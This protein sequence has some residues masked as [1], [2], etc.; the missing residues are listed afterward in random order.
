MLSPSDSQ[1]R[2]SKSKKVLTELLDVQIDL[3]EKLK[4]EN[5]QYL[6][7][8][9]KFLALITKKEK[10]IDELKINLQKNAK[11]LFIFMNNLILEN[12]NFALSNLKSALK[13]FWKKK[14]LEK[15]LNKMS[16]RNL[17]KHFIGFKIN[18]IRKT[19]KISAAIV[20]ITFM[21]KIDI[22]KQIAFSKLFKTCFYSKQ[23]NLQNKITKIASFKIFYFAEK[24]ERIIYKK[25]CY[26]IFLLKWRNNVKLMISNDFKMKNMINIFQ[27]L[28]N[29]FFLNNKF[30]FLL[31]ISKEKESHSQ[32]YHNFISLIN[33]FI[34]KKVFWMNEFI[35]FEKIK[36]YARE[37]NIFEKKISK[38]ATI[39]F[40][41]QKRRLIFEL[42]LKTSQTSKAKLL[43]HAVKTLYAKQVIQC[44][45]F[46]RESPFQIPYFD[47]SCFQKKKKNVFRDKNKSI[48]STRSK[49][50]KK[51]KKN[52]KI[53][54]P[55][56]KNKL[57]S[58]NNATQTFFLNKKN[59]FEVYCSTMM[60][61]MKE[62]QEN[63]EKK[64]EEQKNFLQNKKIQDD[65]YHK[66]V[67]ENQLFGKQ[68]L[69][70]Q[71]ALKI[72]TKDKEKMEINLKKLGIIN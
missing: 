28:Q 10:I 26:K 13:Y 30:Q 41:L 18:C 37:K 32:K 64:N 5:N 40:N 72:Q 36:A 29:Q 47:F 15:V 68:L 54:L 59:E 25:K 70:K 61:L 35:S 60:K 16:F 1:D 22:R 66:L 21:K 23:K 24:V 4:E 63:L 34:C 53:S 48:F 17:R 65:N 43:F 20:L 69:E 33:K 12:K 62:S 14:S 38:I 58:H 50:S 7:Q 27:K 9:K 45:W 57:M 52:K 51:N 3:N 2:E 31:G 67:Q 46:L 8:Q 49:I 11:P 39:F 44:F 71:E 56:I 42:K 55:E 6:E 19:N